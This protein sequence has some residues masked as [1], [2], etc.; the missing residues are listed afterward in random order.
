MATWHP[1]EGDKP[2]WL[3]CN[4]PGRVDVAAEM[5]HLTEAGRRQLVER[6]L[7]ELDTKEQLRFLGKFANC[8]A[9][10][11]QDA[12]VQKAIQLH[13]KRSTTDY[14]DGGPTEEDLV[15]YKYAEDLV[16]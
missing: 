1:A 3:E 10:V 9:A 16:G 6:Y 2:G 12:C 11:F 8:T 7:P 13:F 14:D 15:P 5:A 4:R